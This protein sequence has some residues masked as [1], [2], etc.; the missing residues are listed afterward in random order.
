[1]TDALSRLRE[2]VSPPEEPQYNVGD[3]EAV[4]H[5]LGLKLPADYKQLIE[6][7]GQGEFR[8]HKYCAGLFIASYLGPL[9]PLER[10]STMAIAF[11]ALKQH[12]PLPYAT[13]PERSGL[14]GFG[15]YGGEDAIAWVTLGEPDDW[16]IVYSDLETGFS[17]FKGVG[18]LKFVID[19]LEETSPLQSENVIRFGEMAGPH[20]FEYNW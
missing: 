13:Y 5:D 10:A 15:S 7:Y 4:E 6:A 17:E 3:W 19:V 16:P 9:T 1:M 2:L 8:G 11:E 12:T 14:L 20:T 18:L